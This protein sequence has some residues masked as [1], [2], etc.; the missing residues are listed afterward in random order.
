MTH[1]LPYTLTPVQEAFVRS[2]AK[3]TLFCGGIGS[4]KTFAGAVRFLSHY[5]AGKERDGQ[6]P[7]KLSRGYI[8]ANTFD[9]LR[10]ATLEEFFKVVEQHG[11]RWETNWTK[12]EI[13][14]LPWSYDVWRDATLPERFTVHFKSLE[15]FNDLRG[16]E[17]GHFWLDEA[18]DV[19]KEAWDIVRGR[20]RQREGGALKG[21]LTS[22]PNGLR[23]WLYPHFEKAELPNS[24]IIHA[25][26]HDNRANLPEGYIEDLERSYEG[27]WFEQELLGA[28]TSVQRGRCYKSFSRE[29]HAASE[30]LA[31]KDSDALVGVD[32]NV[33][34]MTAV[35]AQEIALPQGKGLKIVAEFHKRDSNTFDLRDWLREFKELKLGKGR[36]ITCVPDATGNS[37]GS[38]SETTAVGVLAGQFYCRVPKTNPSHVDRVHAVERLL[39]ER[40]LFVAPSCKNL[41]ESLEVTIWEDGALKIDK[42]QGAEHISDALGYLICE[43][44]GHQRTR[45]ETRRM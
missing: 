32:F 4:G 17:M 43:H 34:P 8:L 44:F 25:R 30:C 36:K 5:R 9:Q 35:V 28:F 45:I 3:F 27:G 20:L 41:I 15:R 39:R 7:G 6:A 10:H 1:P 23:H 24:R 19:E 2:R 12:R 42:R 40:R 29:I 38:A 26:T 31:D 22:T 14:I 21:D 37:R 18:R 11:F 13:Q 16:V 33:D